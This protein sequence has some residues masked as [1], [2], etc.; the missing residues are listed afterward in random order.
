MMTGS[1]ADGLDL[2]L[3]D[4]W[5]G[6]HGV[7]FNVRYSTEIEYPER[8]KAAFSNPLQL[9]DNEIKSF[10][11]DLGQWFAQQLDSIIFKYDV[12]ANHGQTIK[13]DPPNYSLQIGDPSFMSDRS[14]KPVVFDFRSADIDL[15]GQGA[16]LIPI[17]DKLL[18]QDKVLDKL[19]LNIGGIS[20]I[21]VIPSTS[22][23]KPLLAWDIGPG[24]T[25]IDKA[26]K[27]YTKNSHSFDREGRI[28]AKG[29]LNI[30]VLNY[31]MSNKFYGLPQ[32]KSAGQEQF[33]YQYFNKLLELFPLDNDAALVD[34]IHT[35]TVLTARTIGDAI[36]GIDHGYQ[37]NEIFIGGG[38]TFNNTLVSL[39]HDQLPMIKLT[40]VDHSGITESNKEAVGF[41]YLGYLRLMER[42]GNIPSVTGAE[43]EVRL[44]RICRPGE[45]HSDPFFS[46]K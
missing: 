13:H 34:L 7:E 42:A 28:A 4:F 12:I 45:D 41:A 39:L 25:L 29:K 31:L 21:T 6:L 9:T 24:N 43:K 30:K 15:N 2:A 16:P 8:F 10:H 44:G 46:S 5:E 18:F 27:L 23:S 37:P 32:P 3:V 38:G 11:Q 33:G 1:S 22:N 19:S 36:R 20:N 40:R 14:R 26:V 17:F 35:L